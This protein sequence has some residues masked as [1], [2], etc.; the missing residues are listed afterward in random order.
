MDKKTP[1]LLALLALTTPAGAII[2]LP[3]SLP[4]Y[5]SDDFVGPLTPQQQAEKDAWK[6]SQQQQALDVVGG[7]CVPW[8]IP[9]KVPENADEKKLT[10]NGTTPGG[11]DW[12]QTPQGWSDCSSGICKLPATC[13]ANPGMAP[14]KAENE[15]KAKEKELALKKSAED[16]ANAR[17]WGNQPKSNGG[18]SLLS[19]GLG[20]GL[21]G[22][23]G[24]GA[25]A[26]GPA[27]ASGVK[28]V[29]EVPTPLAD[30]GGVDSLVDK[31]L[32]G[33]P[34]N[35]PLW[36]PDDAAR[37]YGE[38]NV[39]LGQGLTALAANF[40]DNGNAFSVGSP[41]RPA[42]ASGQKVSSIGQL[43]RVGGRPQAKGTSADTIM[44][45]L[46]SAITFDQMKPGEAKPVDPGYRNS[47]FFN[48]R[49]A[50][51]TE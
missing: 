36:S 39:G 6:L 44:D 16:E 9:C 38:G 21:G 49:P 34:D 17:M 46:S 27:D 22:S 40:T 10:E 14:C 41:G 50:Q 15:R 32:D 48:T 3:A 35:S 4:A 20:G 1:L 5:Y 25:E 42:A 31:I 45:W 12:V 37:G 7:G 2:T 11:Q 18:F 51:P 29:G 47:A 30:N 43:H 13:E 8:R 28:T 19:A 33:Q 23:M 24:G 26:G